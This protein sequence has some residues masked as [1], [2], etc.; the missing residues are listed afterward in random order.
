M[1]K[2]NQSKRLTD[3][4]KESQ[5]VVGIFGGGAK[6]HDMTVG[7]ISHFVIEQLKKEFPQLSFRYKNSIKKEEINEALKKVDPELG[8]TL[9]VSNSNIKLHFPKKTHWL[10]HANCE[11]FNYRILLS[12]YAFRA[13]Q[14]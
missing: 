1:A 9:F 5:G 6:S 10:K 8:Q 4:H 7:E 11:R 13:K 2:K 14:H 12:L 3:Q